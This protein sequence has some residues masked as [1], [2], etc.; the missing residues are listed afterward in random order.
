MKPID[1][2]SAAFASRRFD[3]GLRFVLRIYLPRTLGLILGG[4]AV[5]AVLF[6]NGAHP[7]TWLALAFTALVWPHVAYWL[8]R[9][10]AD[11]YRTEL[12]NFMIDSALGGAWI[13]LMQFN[14]LPSVLLFVML[15]MDKL[16]VGGPR[17]LARCTAAL[18]AGCA[19]AA[20]LMAFTGGLEARPYTNMLEIVASLPLL[21]VYPGAVVLTSYRMA[22]QLRFQNRELEAVSRTDGVSQM[23]TRHAWEQVVADE[24]EVCRR[25]GQP[26]CLLMADI[27]QVQAI[28]DRHGY[29]AGD[30]VIRSVATILRNSLRD[31]DVPG[32]YGG[33][34]FCALLPG[35]DT[36]AAWVI[37]E[38]GRQRVE[39][40]VLE[41]SARVL[42]TVCIGI[43]QF[44]PQDGDYREWISRA[45]QALR[46]A[47]A[48]GRNHI[49]RFEVARSLPKSA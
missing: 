36:A 21:I 31:Q 37:A 15:S 22:R 27:D 24:F 12:R 17:F 25:L 43:A 35:T 30:Q 34:E 26:A 33:E 28:N 10:S 18:V 2:G 7:L 3:R 20:A 8:G 9:R 29:P 38:R 11:P 23:L 6:T 44:D 45:D 32:R 5:G 46:A 19:A 4:V 39:S 13:A 40:A 41:R 49:A 16:S 48:Q 47:K 1:S 14:L 42:G